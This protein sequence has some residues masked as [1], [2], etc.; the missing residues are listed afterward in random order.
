MN[1]LQNI[2]I[3]KFRNLTMLITFI[4]NNIN[5]FLL[6]LFLYSFCL[7]CLFLSPAISPRMLKGKIN[8]PMSIY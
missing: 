7:D 2:R 1:G 8:Q 6:E 3:R 4:F 5:F